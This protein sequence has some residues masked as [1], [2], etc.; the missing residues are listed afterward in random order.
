MK[1]SFPRH[2]H[3]LIN[4]RIPSPISLENKTIEGVPCTPHYCP[5]R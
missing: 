5:N 4:Q 1:P 3:Q 2:L